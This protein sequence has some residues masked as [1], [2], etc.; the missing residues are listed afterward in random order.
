M[1][2]LLNL[3]S[4][5]QTPFGIWSILQILNKLGHKVTLAARKDYGLVKMPFERGGKALLAEELRHFSP[6][7][8][9]ISTLSPQAIYL[10]AFIGFLKEQATET[11][12]IVG[13]YHTLIWQEKL[14][15]DILDLDYVFYGEA[16]DELPRFLEEFQSD[17]PDFSKIKGLIYRSNGTITKNE[18]PSAVDINTTNTLEPSFDFINRKIWEYKISNESDV[19]VP[20]SNLRPPLLKNQHIFT[21]RYS[22]GPGASKGIEELRNLKCSYMRYTERE[23]AAPLLPI[24][25][26]IDNIKN[27]RSKF[28][29][30]NFPMKRLSYTAGPADSMLLTRGCPFHCAFCSLHFEAPYSKVRHLSPKIFSDQLDYLVGRG[31]RGLWIADANFGLNKRY[32]KEIIEIIKSKREIIDWSCYVNPKTVNEDLLKRMRDARC[33]WVGMYLE[34]GTDRI[35]NEVQRKGFTNQDILRAYELAKKCNLEISSN[36]IVANPS[37]TYEELLESLKFYFS[38]AKKGIS[39]G[40]VL[41]AMI[42]PGT[43]WWTR[44]EQ[45]NLV[46]ND[47]NCIGYSKIPKELA[48]DL[49]KISVYMHAASNFVRKIID[50]TN[51][52]VLFI[53]Q[54][55][56]NSFETALGMLYSVY[57][58]ES[59]PERIDFLSEPCTANINMTVPSK[60]YPLTYVDDYDKNRKL[61]KLDCL[62]NGN[63]VFLGKEILKNICRTAYDV[64]VV[65]LDKYEFNSANILEIGFN[66]NSSPEIFWIIP[67]QRRIIEYNLD[68]KSF[69]VTTHKNTIHLGPSNTGSIGP[70][71]KETFLSF[72]F[73]QMLPR[74]LYER[75]SNL[76]K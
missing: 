30:Y 60:I 69:S 20:V 39:T 26:S 33:R 43:E 22:E 58:T 75:V 28:P 72:V 16:E 41:E 40:K 21:N 44:C 37:E 8:I 71:N 51:K 9:G 34:S 4:A 47:P 23:I 64:I 54:S 17:K 49:D 63:D 66:M 32:Y 1:R 35:R 42:L 59:L 31:K 27:I 45:L 14:L 29:D 2:I 62:T 56:I 53:Q 50:I 73:Y 48:P 11:P 74:R 61:N 36:L 13:G 24:F 15:E 7:L 38:L 19:H 52:K 3:F 18:M 65:T 6:D 55:S 5:Y 76:L 70:R 68:Y 25:Q 67:H 10:D 46:E 57:L 12:I